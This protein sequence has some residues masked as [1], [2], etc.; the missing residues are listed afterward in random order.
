MAHRMIWIAEYGMIPVA[1]QINHKNGRRWD[2]RIDNLEVVTPR[3]NSWH[4]YGMVYDAVAADGDVPPGWLRVLDKGKP[5]ER[6]FNPFDC[7]R[8]RP[9][10]FV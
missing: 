6:A 2:N 10:R 5:I 7:G 1:L 4:A 3:G 8:P 9:G